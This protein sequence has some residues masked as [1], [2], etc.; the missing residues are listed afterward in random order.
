MEFVRGLHA[1]GAKVTGIGERARDA[2]PADLANQMVHY[3]RVGSVCD[4][5]EMIHTVRK[6]HEV[7]PVD[8]M[9]ATVEA[10][11]L[12]IARVREACGIPGTSVETTWACRDKPTMKQ[13][14][15]DAGIAT[16]QSAG[17]SSPEEAREFA[18][19]VGYP[20]ILK[21]RGG[22]GASGTFRVD[23]DAGLEG[24][25]QA[26]GLGHGQSVAIE[27]FVEGHEGFYDT[28]TV[29]GRVTHDFVTHYFPN[30]L[31]A[32]RT[33]WISPQFVVTN[34]IDSVDDYAQVRELGRRV[35]EAL[36][37]DTAPT[38]MEWFFGPKGLKFSEIGCRPPGV[39]AWDLYC[40]ANEMDLYAEWAMAVCWGR[41]SR[42]PSRRYSAG[43]IS[44]RPDGDGTISGYEGLE[45][46]QREY[47]EWII[48]FHF[49]N[50]GTPTQEVEAGYMANAWLRMRHPDY[51]EL[52]GMLNRV[53][54]TVKVKTR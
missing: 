39:G 43:I 40:A 29:G 52:R 13:V 14:L 42:A 9:E 8:R 25:I 32:M 49:P 30:V 31:E 54:E 47:G 7:L 18:G 37:L 3:E 12:P 16:A 27:E 10:H 20:L 41:T 5:D 11:V 50:P 19:R 44:L 38:H 6:V 1:V 2:L 46:I 15:R 4:E 28:L 23:D 35:I 45:Q 21:P 36:R 22:A 26:S 34:R 33:R 17:A 53:G 51:D 24:A 48:D